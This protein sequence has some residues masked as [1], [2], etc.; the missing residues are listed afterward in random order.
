MFA[1]A[2]A[3]AL[4]FA[5]H[6]EDEINARTSREADGAKDSLAAP[7]LQDGNAYKVSFTRFYSYVIFTHSYLE[8]HRFVPV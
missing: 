6:I 5:K 4:F 1:V 7:L 8:Y 2:L 3:G